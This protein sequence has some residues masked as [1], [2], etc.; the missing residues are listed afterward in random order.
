M[1][2]NQHMLGHLARRFQQLA[3]AVFFGEVEACGCELTPVQY[4]ALLGVHHHPGIDQATLS[5]IIAYDRATIGGVVDRL[6]KKGLLTRKV[7]KK[8]RRARELYVTA[9]GLE[10]LHR[11]VPAVEAAQRNLAHGLTRTEATQLMRLLRKA[12][13]A[14]DGMNGTPLRIKP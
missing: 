8:D 12:I 10:T 5:G 14:A 3:V 1:Q 9:V 11:I 7:N 2:D 4:A 13:N 6:K